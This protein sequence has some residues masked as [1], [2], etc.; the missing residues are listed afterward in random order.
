[1]DFWERCAQRLWE[2]IPDV[3]ES[4]DAFPVQGEGFRLS[5]GDSGAAVRIGSAGRALARA[6]ARNCGNPE[7]V[8]VIEAGCSEIAEPRAERAQSTGSRKTFNKVKV[9]GAP[10]MTTAMANSMSMPAQMRLRVFR[11]RPNSA[12]MVAGWAGPDVG[13]QVFAFQVG[14]G[15]ILARQPAFENEP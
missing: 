5:T 6:C 2:R 4:G 3:N 15:T 11:G 10:R 1:M 12:A 7:M 8:R 13:V 14:H 9:T